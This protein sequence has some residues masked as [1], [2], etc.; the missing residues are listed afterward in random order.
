MNVLHF[1]NYREENIRHARSLFK[2][3][4][5]IKNFIINTSQIFV[6]PKTLKKFLA[7]KLYFIF[8]HFVMEIKFLTYILDK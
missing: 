7:F 5:S 8:E 6:C 3:I 4:L 2:S 1:L